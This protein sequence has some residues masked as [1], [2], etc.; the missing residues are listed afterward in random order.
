MVSSAEGLGLKNQEKKKKKSP[1]FSRRTP[2]IALSLLLYQCP[3]LYLLWSSLSASFSP[4]RILE[5]SPITFQGSLWCSPE[6]Q[7]NQQHGLCFS[8]RSTSSSH[9]GLGSRD[10]ILRRTAW[11]GFLLHFF[12]PHSPSYLAVKPLENVREAEVEHLLY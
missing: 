4:A 11:E 10:Y 5:P 3:C 1:E 7:V 12:S 2:S 6:M 8:Q 9:A